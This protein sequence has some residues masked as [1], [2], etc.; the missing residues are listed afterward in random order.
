MPAVARVMGDFAGTY[1]VFARAPDRG[2]IVV[3]ILVRYP[4]GPYG[5]LLRRAMPWLDLLMFR[6]QL[7][8]LKRYAERDA[9]DAA[10]T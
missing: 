2:R 4:R 3:R 8:T 9:K 5:A 7:A 10:G 6:K 1:R